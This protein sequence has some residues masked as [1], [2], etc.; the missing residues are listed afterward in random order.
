MKVKIGDYICTDI[1]PCGTV[2]WES[3][4]VRLLEN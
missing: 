2:V 1:W 4:D 3:D